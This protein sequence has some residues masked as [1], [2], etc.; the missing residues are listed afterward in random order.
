[1]GLAA[2]ALPADEVFDAALAYAR[3]VAVNTAPLSVALSKRLLWHQPSLDAEECDRLETAYHRVVMP[4]ALKV[5]VS[6]T[7]GGVTSSK[8]TTLTGTCA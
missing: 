5:I 6:A 4:I 1:M 8:R 2:A 7:P 3:D